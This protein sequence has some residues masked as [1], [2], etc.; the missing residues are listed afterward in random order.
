MS[1][2]SKI[3]SSK[4][5]FGAGSNEMSDNSDKFL[6]KQGYYRK[7][8]APDSTCLF[9]CVSELRHDI[10]LYHPEVRK[11]CVEYMRNNKKLFEKEIKWNYYDYIYNMSRPQTYGTILELQALAWLHKANVHIFTPFKEPVVL[12]DEPSH[13]STWRLFRKRDKQFD[14]VFSIEYMKSAAYCQSI[15]YEVLMKNVLGLP[16]IEYMTERMLYDPNNEKTTYEVN[17]EG[18]PVAITEDG[19]QLVLSTA[20]ETN[21]ALSQS[22]LCHFHNRDGFEDVKQFFEVQGTEKGYQ[23]YLKDYYQTIANKPSPLLHD[24]EISCIRQLLEMHI[25]PVPYRVAKSLDPHTYRNV[26]YDTWMDLRREANIATMYQM[27]YHRYY[28]TKTMRTLR[29][30]HLLRD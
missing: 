2:K 22:D 8:I 17:E 10:Q 11:E 5:E 29:F 30:L 7:H 25:S 4:R 3:A 19:R 18:R 20:Q 26:E 14:V 6:F 21:C 27:E 28:F 23:V 12:V 24:P 1:D 9:R 16:D 15:V 13:E